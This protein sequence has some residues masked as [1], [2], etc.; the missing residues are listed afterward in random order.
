MTKRF[1]ILAAAILLAS[2]LGTS[3]APAETGELPPRYRQW[4][5]KDA[6][7]LIGPKEKEVFLSLASDRERDLFIEAFWKQRDPTPGTDR[8]EF[9]EEHY[10]RMAYADQHFGRSGIKP[11]WKTDRGRVHIILGPPRQDF[12]YDQDAQVRP[13][14]IWFYEGLSLPGLP[15]GFS[16][17]FYKPDP[18]S[19]YELYSPVAD[20]PAR[21]LRG[22]N[23]D[24]TDYRAA[25]S[26]LLE[27]EP[28]VARVSLSL[29][30][31]EGQGLQSPSLAS[32]VLLDN[33]GRAPLRAVDE[34][35]AVRFRKYKDVV[36]V[37]YSVNSI[38]NH[39]LVVV[40]PGPGGMSFV[41]YAVEPARLSVEDEGDS[42]TTSLE[43]NGQVRDPRGR[44]IFQFERRTP[45]SLSREQARSL[46]SRPVS[47]QGLFPLAE[48]TYDLSLILK[49]TAS[50]EFTTVEERVEVP[51]PARA[52]DAGPLLAAYGAKAEPGLSE[53]RAFL[54]GQTQF[55]VPPRGEF[56]PGDTLTA[57]LALRGPGTE[58]ARARSA[59]FEL[60]DMQGLVKA[61]RTQDLGPEPDLVR[62]D[63]ELAGLPSAD[64]RLRLSILDA[65]GRPIL[66]RTGILGV[67][68]VARVPRPLVFSDPMPAPGDPL[69]GYVLGEQYFNLGDLEKATA[70]ARAG[71]R[72]RTSSER[73]AL[74]Y[75]RALLAGG[76]FDEALGVLG[77][78]YRSG[79]GEAATVEFTAEAFRALGRNAEAVEACEQY[80]DRFGAKLAILNALGECALKMGDRD[81]A[82]AA[83]SR[84]LQ[85]NPDQEEIRR[86]ADSI[87]R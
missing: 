7:Y 6:A 56:A 62:A 36:E 34:A 41:H 30:P 4:L 17:V 87:R 20:G 33:I 5:D 50:K 58:R 28:E 23:L 9:R 74:G 72:G 73:F 3:A 67:A 79:R 25:Y 77:P 49:N 29:L 26:R 70:F 12:V 57:A 18:A 52:L 75:A 14:E 44:T 65:S 59:R 11:G 2:A 81:T 27:T 22:G 64:Y 40:L 42:L 55:F 63:I 53:M 84:S 8:N 31:D 78:F 35:Y 46:G 48:G 32:Q 68:P 76:G 10:R 82:L 37:E 13:V 66:V 83:W 80:L 86:A 15:E 71:Y 51:A 19:D 54:I 38:G 61:A 43:L 69:Y 1:R 60:E 16:C 85:I 39:S 24:P 21:L 45:I 47:I